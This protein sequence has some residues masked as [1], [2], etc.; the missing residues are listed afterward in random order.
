MRLQISG[1]V[2]P[3]CLTS[4]SRFATLTKNSSAECLVQNQTPSLSPFS[5]VYRALMLLANR[6]SKL[7]GSAG[8]NITIH[9]QQIPRRR[10]AHVRKLLSL[11]H[12][13]KQNSSS[14]LITHFLLPAPRKKK[15]NTAGHSE[16]QQQQHLHL[17]PDST[18]HSKVM[19][20][21]C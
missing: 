5:R 3:R 2:V 15:K 12:G 10:Q 1:S 11:Q 21:P 6:C 13:A 4:A 14:S 18:H 16:Q 19:P 9:S 8:S 7:D 17:L 20:H